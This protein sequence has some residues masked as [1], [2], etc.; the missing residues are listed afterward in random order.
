[1]KGIF[2]ITEEVQKKYC[3]RSSTCKR[4]KEGFVV[5]GALGFCFCQRRLNLA[6][7]RWVGRAAIDPVKAGKWLSP[8]PEVPP[9]RELEGV[10]PVT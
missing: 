1:M 7:W 2:S 4:L 3:T 9:S 6:T 8:G 10:D 5:E